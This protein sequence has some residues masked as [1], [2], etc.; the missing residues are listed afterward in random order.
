MVSLV[1]QRV[2][3]ND[4]LLNNVNKNEYKFEYHNWSMDRHLFYQN[5]YNKSWNY[6]DQNWMN[7]LLLCDIVFE[8]S[9]LN[10]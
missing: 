1:M 2:T 7:I 6:V 10:I 4:D 5:N 9:L 3:G 8:V